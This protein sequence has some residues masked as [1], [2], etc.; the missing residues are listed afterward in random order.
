MRWLVKSLALLALLIAFHAF[1]PGFPQ[2]ASPPPSSTAAGEVR[3]APRAMAH[4]VERHGADSEARGAGKFAAGTMEAQIR[5][6]IAEAVRQGRPSA[7]TNG[8]PGT[9][10]DYVFPHDIGIS[11][12]GRPTRRLR[13]VVG[14]D[15][16][17][18]TAFPR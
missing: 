8:R 15:G 18:V 3:I 14:S 1:G 12:D 2:G 11:I 13:V 10:Y 17:V 6:M 5:A 9:L 4:I 16:G 7:N